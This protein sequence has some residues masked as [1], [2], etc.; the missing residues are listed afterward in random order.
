MIDRKNFSFD[1]LVNR[2]TPTYNIYGNFMTN[3]SNDY[4]TGMLLFYQWLEPKYKFTA[5]N[6]S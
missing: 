2:K 6:S 5:T 3:L 1:G 4:T